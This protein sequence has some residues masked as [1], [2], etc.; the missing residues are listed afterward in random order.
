MAFKISG[1]NPKAE[2]WIHFPPQSGGV[3]NRLLSDGH[4]KSTAFCVTMRTNIIGKTAF[5]D[6][7]IRK[8]QFSFRSSLVRSTINV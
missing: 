4:F 2:P 7:C 1:I 6:S 8:K 3:L 5:Y